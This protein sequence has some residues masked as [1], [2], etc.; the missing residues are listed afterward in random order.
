ML[1]SSSGATV[2]D[3]KGKG[4]E[5][6]SGTLSGRRSAERSV[7]TRAE[8]LLK[9][10]KYDPAVIR[11][12]PEAEEGVKELYLSW[13]QAEI[14]SKEAGLDSK[15]WADKMTL[16]LAELGHGEALKATHDVLGEFLDRTLRFRT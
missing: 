9:Q 8:A 3:A 7:A 12:D 10:L 16:A 13:I 15:E 1:P 6:G 5:V 2:S 14:D 11:A 4:K